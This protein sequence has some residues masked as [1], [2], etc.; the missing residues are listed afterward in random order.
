M[1]ILY[2]HFEKKIFK[3]FNKIFLRPNENIEYYNNSHKNYIY[4]EKVNNLL[5]TFHGFYKDNY[6]IIVINSYDEILN[7][8]I[9]HR[10]VI[11]L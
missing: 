3:H 1:D 10:E 7:I 4:T 9:E 11:I 5:Y 6:F 2:L 8:T